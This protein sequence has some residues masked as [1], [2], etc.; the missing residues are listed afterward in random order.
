MPAYLLQISIGV[1]PSFEK[2]GKKNYDPKEK[3]KQK[4]KQTQQRDDDGKKARTRVRKTR[5]TLR[6]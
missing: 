3:Q 4:Q 5:Q 1:T 6:C 2:K